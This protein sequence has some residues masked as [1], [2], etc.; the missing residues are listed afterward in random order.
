MSTHRRRHAA[1]ALAA[2][3]LLALTGCGASE[4]S[5]PSS[6][7]A[8]GEGATSYPVTLDNCGTSTTVTAAPQRVVSLDQDSTEILL[9]L[10]L[11]DRMVGT[12]SWTDPI[13]D[14]LASANESVPR[15]ADNAPS[16][17]VLL[18]AD[19]DFVTAS[20]GRHYAAEGVA[21][22]ERLAETGI[23]SYLAP[24]DCDSGQSVNGGSRTRSVPLTVDSLYQ[25]I[26]ELA[27]VFDVQKRGDALV[28]QL[29]ARAATATEGVD[30]GGRSVA[31]WFADTKTPY[32]AGG[33]N[34]ASMLGTM[35]GMTNVFADSTD[36][37]PAAGWESVV[38]A[39]PDVLV[40]GDLQRDRFPGDRLDDKIE[41]LRSDP[42]TSTL[43]AVQKGRFIALHGAELNPS[44]RFVDGLDK[45]R[46]WWDAN[47]ASL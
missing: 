16:Y 17:E 41:F 5:D 40:L 7:A 39:A 21:S 46:A 37:W 31:F 28:A 42:L 9:S 24:T 36:D 2:L 23:G 33:Y 12:A 27:E 47:G 22:R 45:I 6:T 18:G 34:F 10:G 11:E 44:I 4:Q 13:L 20:F 25:E 14:T 29:K 8:A 43:P 1:L 38:A 15:L 26:H 32:M 35:T 19:P 3:T 30:F